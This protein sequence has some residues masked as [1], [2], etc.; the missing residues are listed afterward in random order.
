VS[1]VCLIL[2]GTYPYVTGGVSSCVYQLIK[3]TPQVKYNILYIGASAEIKQEYKY[4]IP[5]NVRL[6][7][8]VFLYDYNIKGKIKKVHLEGLGS[9]LKNFHESP[10][11]VKKE[12]FDILYRKLFDP[13]TRE[14][15]PLKLLESDLAWDYIEESYKRKFGETEEVS[16]I[17]YF[18]NWRFTHYPIF[19]L[20]T[21]DI[22][23]ANLYHSLCTGYAGL[24]GVAAKKLYGK[25]LILT[26]HGIY[27]HEREIE[28]YQADWIYDTDKD[29]KAKM[30]QSH[31]KEWWIKLFHFMGHLAYDYADIITT[32]YD[33]NLQKQVKYGADPEKIEIIANGI[34]VEKFKNIEVNRCS[35]KFTI[36]L[37]GRVVPIKDIKTFIKSIGFVRNHLP[38]IEVLIMGPEDEDPEYAVECHQLTELLG[39]SEIIKFTGKVDIKDYFGKIH[40]MVLSS[41]SEGQP[42]VILEGFATKIPVVSTDVGSCSELVYGRDEED[43]ELG[44]AG[45]IVPFG[46]PQELGEAIVK[47]LSDPDLLASM[48]EVAFERV[49]RYYKEE[50]TVGNY[51]N[52]YTKYL[53][54]SF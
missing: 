10:L 28:I 52:L 49:N 15:N 29:V 40:L 34:D 7:K 26:E 48:S 24:M 41:I 54:R 23:R 4:P 27:S 36:A 47:V 30:G 8:K 5:D 12:Y 11:G 21:T 37:V 9:D 43:K 32:L 19:K 3:N 39:L 33:G 1:D 51:Y 17:D 42:M 22:P 6:I 46:K 38:N 18:Y 20:L 53:S 13:I 2:E 25:P 35:E 45:E 50:M 31:F 14:F 44:K 16:F